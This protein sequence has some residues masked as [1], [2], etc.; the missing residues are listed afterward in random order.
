MNYVSKILAAVGVTVSA[1][2]AGCAETTF[3]DS[4]TLLAS[5][6]VKGAKRLRASNASELVVRYEPMHGANQRYDVDIS[7]P[8]WGNNPTQ[9]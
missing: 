3:E 4:G 2:L 5:A 8:P 9:I 7:T 6:V 1:L